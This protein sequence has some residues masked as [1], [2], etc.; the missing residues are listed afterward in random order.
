MSLMAVNTGA[1]QKVEMIRQPPFTL[2]VFMHNDAGFGYMVKYLC[3]SPGTPSLFSQQ[4]R[5]V[6][7]Y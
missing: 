3:F 6:N 1:M 7:W 2:L 5:S 4:T